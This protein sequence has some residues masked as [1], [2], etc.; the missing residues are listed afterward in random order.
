MFVRA[1]TVASC[2][3]GASFTGVAASVIVYALTLCAAP[4]A[5]LSL[6]TRKRKAETNPVPF[7]GGVH[8]SVA[9]A[10]TATAWSTVTGVPPSANVPRSRTGSDAMVTL[11][12]ASLSTSV[13]GKSVAAK[14]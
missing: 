10:A 14:V 4:S 6:T 8:T 11:A 13:K 7:S 12:S 5:S 3:V 1:V 2:D 9:M